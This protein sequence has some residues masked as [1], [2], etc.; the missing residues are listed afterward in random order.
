MGN[1][2]LVLE[3]NLASKTKIQP[4]MPE[5]IGPKGTASHCIYPE[6]L[7]NVGKVITSSDERMIKYDGKWEPK[8]LQG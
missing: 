4:F 5:E 7:K 1:W 2:N 3:N 6:Q 8:K